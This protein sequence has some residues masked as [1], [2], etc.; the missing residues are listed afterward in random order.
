MGTRILHTRTARAA[1]ALPA[2]LLLP[3]TAD[4]GA[5]TVVAV[6]RAHPAAVSDTAFGFPVGPL[7][8]SQDG[9]FVAFTSASPNL[10]AG[11]VGDGQQDVYLLD[12]A[13]NTMTLVSHQAGAPSRGA[14]GSSAN[15]SLSADGRYLAF[16]SDA[17][18][19]VAGV[20]DANYTDDVFLFDRWSGGVRLV[21]HKAGAPLVAAGR[22]SSSA[23]ISTDGS[24][25]AFAS[26][27]LDLVT[28]QSDVPGTDDVFLYDVTADT[29]RL[30]S[31]SVNGPTTT[32]NRPAQL[33]DVSADGRRV[34]FSSDSTNLVIGQLDTNGDNDVFV[35]DADTGGVALV[36]HVPGLA[37]VAAD[38]ASSD[39]RLSADGTRVAFTSYAGNLVP[40]QSGG[41]FY[42]RQ[43]FLAEPATGGATLVS[44][45]ATAPSTAAD[46][47][48]S[49]PRIDAAGATVAFV[50]W[51]GDLV[52]GAY[53]YG[54]NVYV[55]DRA[56]GLNAVVSAAPGPIAIE[57]TLTGLSS[58]GRYVSY[59]SY[60]NPGGFIDTNDTR[61]VFLYDRA[62]GLTLLVS[63]R[64]GT[65]DTTGNGAS[66]DSVLSVDGTLTAFVT[67]ATDGVAGVVDTNDTRDV[68]AHAGGTSTLVSRRDLA[69]P[70]GTA[71]LAGSV[72]PGAVSDDGRF[73]AFVSVSHDIVP[74]MVDPDFNAPDVFL[75]DTLTRATVLVSHAPAAPLTGAGG[76]EACISGD[77]R[78]VAFSSE[79]R[80]VPGQTGAY[81]QTFLYERA[82]GLVNLVSHA[83]GTPTAGG[84]GYSIPLG[85]SRDGRYV[86]FDSLA[87]DLVAGTNDAN[88]YFDLFLYDR[89]A[90]ASVL[91][92]HVAGSPST[93]PSALFFG[94][95]ALAADGDFVAYAHSATDLVAG[96]NDTNSD[97]D[98]F[99]YDRASG[100][101]TLASHAASSATTTAS[102]GSRDVSISGDGAWVSFISGATDL[103]AGQVDPD[104][105]SD[106]F[107]F[108]RASGAN[109]LVSHAAG[110]PTISANNSSDQAV[111]S[112]DGK[113]LAFAS[114]ANDLVS[115]VSATVFGSD[116][117]LYDRILDA[118]TLVSHAAGLPL[119][120][121]NA[122]SEAPSVS[123]DGRQ[124]AFESFATNLVAG[125]VGGQGAL[126]ADAFRFSR[127]SGE[128]VLA[129]RRYGT[130][131]TGA[132]G[133]D[134]YDATMQISADGSVLVFESTAATLVPGDFNGRRDVFLFSVRHVK[135]DLNDDLNT[136]L[137]LRSLSQP[138]NRVWTLDGNANRIAEIDVTPDQTGTDWRL[139]GV[140][141]FNG[142]SSSDLVFRNVTTGAVE[143]WM[144]SG[145]TRQGPPVPLGAP[146]PDLGWELAA[147][148]DFDHDGRPDLVWRNTTSQQLVIWTMNG[149]TP[150]G[151]IT[152][153]PSQAAAGNWIV[154]AALDLDVDGNT[155]LLWYNTTSGRIVRWLMDAQVQRITGQFT[156]PM[157]AGDANWKV[158]ASG[159]YGVGPYGSPG[160]LDLVWRN[161][162]SGRFVVWYMDTRGNRTSG[163][164]TNPAAPANPLDW[165]LAGP[166]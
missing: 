108:E 32:T 134:T 151:A 137:V 165:T 162:T 39:A 164:F 74:G 67:W 25:I 83:A 116:V 7:A 105:T 100:T 110:S 12:R 104:Y 50:S 102:Q 88:N 145:T 109:R 54:Q 159:D 138:V 6:T 68:L 114:Y 143:F 70:P 142:D 5:P 38:G 60:G 144:M 47:S 129:S 118:S 87:T 56:S 75:M 103:V 62:A 101:T 149:V 69:T 43:V 111:L 156:N 160:T 11:Y 26:Q 14:N 45:Q 128:S 16:T 49:N 36:S 72:Q 130:T 48:S 119:T 154:V 41:A 58:D 20:T 91:V 131:A 153:V 89:Q 24:R 97:S 148:G 15:P 136:D 113:W 13:T 9:R 124:V 2:V 158:L 33:D 150:V 27:A 55:F 132:G 95:A 37:L 112:R 125:Q 93:T 23:R 155:D 166:R 81:G 115:G 146:A 163:R 31:H 57:G 22:G 106:V 64:A 92:T 53:L 141:D 66:L 63:A 98:V 90:D 96:Q 29:L 147:T 51:S 84:N 65:T 99:V 71:L 10:I 120:T 86:L 3:A 78:F 73:V 35:F 107:L 30:A 126:G 18:D 85:V 82:T 117:Y 61:D 77:G 152:P 19:L 52:A 133:I 135:G 157:Q 139:A 80:L 59:E 46:G 4:A 140:D 44:H 94:D 17:T 122:W 21:S 123:A 121:A 127:D 42:N 28:G 8:T 161:A 34:A 76:A 40:G 1:L 79:A